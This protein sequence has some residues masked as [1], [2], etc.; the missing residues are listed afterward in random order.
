MHF[1]LRAGLAVEDAIVG[2]GRVGGVGIGRPVFAAAASVVA[3]A[4][5]MVFAVT[6]AVVIVVIVPMA[7]VMASLAMLF[8]VPDFE[9]AC[10]TG[11]LLW[12]AR[13]AQRSRRRRK[14]RRPLLWKEAAQ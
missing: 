8:V 14:R 10:K 6:F 4:V 1:D 9:P 7:S 13:P 2:H 5:A 3:V 12:I 11:R